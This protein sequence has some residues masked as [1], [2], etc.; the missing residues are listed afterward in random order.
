MDATAI[1]AALGSLKTILE[2]MKGVS[3]LKLA[4]AVNAEVVNIQAKL[5]DT[6]Q[7][8]LAI[9][10]ENRQ[11]RLEVERSKSYVH[12]HSV[13]WKKIHDTKEDGPFCPTC[14][15]EGREMRLTPK[16][17]VSQETDVWFLWCPRGHLDPRAK[18]QGWGPM[19]QEQTYRLPKT[20][21]PAHYFYEGT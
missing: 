6:Q 8:T 18:Q 17:N 21:V 12:H 5:I 1:S 14:I 4:T 16:P 3:D 9:Q 11:L 10:E 15:G 7:Q 13:T 2:M 19:K 20:L